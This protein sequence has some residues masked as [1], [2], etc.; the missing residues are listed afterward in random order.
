ML[1]QNDPWSGLRVVRELRRG[2]CV[3]GNLIV[4]VDLLLG[5]ATVVAGVG[6]DIALVP[7]LRPTV[8]FGG[9]ILHVLPRYA[10]VLLAFV[11]GRGRAI[12]APVPVGGHLGRR[13]RRDISRISLLVTL[14]IRMSPAIL[15]SVSSPTY[16]VTRFLTIAMVTVSPLSSSLAPW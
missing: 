10:L 2:P 4:E 5:D 11:P 7:W 16:S 9:L 8:L 12:L 6:G 1:V 14:S 3:L 13:P 15:S